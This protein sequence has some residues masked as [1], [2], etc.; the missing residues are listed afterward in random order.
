M[1]EKTSAMYDMT[2]LQ[3]PLNSGL[4]QSK[5]WFHDRV[6]FIQS[7]NDVVAAGRSKAQ[8]ENGARLVFLHRYVSGHIRGVMGDLS[9][10]RDPGEIYLIDQAR[11]VRC[12]QYPTIV[13]GVFLPKEMIGYDES[14]H[15]PFVRFG[16]RPTIGPVIYD[17]FERVLDQ[18]CRDD[19]LDTEA[20]ERLI[21]CLKLAI[22]TD[23]R[24]GD[25]RR[26]AREAMATLIRKFVEENLHQP[27][28]SST[29]ILKNF[30]VSRASLFRMF[31]RDGGVRSFI[32]KRRLNRAVFDLSQQPA[33][34]GAIGAAAYR[35]GFSSDATF[36]RAVRNAFGAPPGELVRTSRTE[37]RF[38]DAGTDILAFTQGI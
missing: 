4:Y 6:M 20:F 18:V 13:Q 9:I 34:R 22:G 1:R 17:A 19:V 10:D 7:K 28:L 15:A 29:S 8:A 2:P 27:S 36:N 38:A 21:S 5:S 32:Q 30:G 26:H 12:I 16:L 3:S 24:S 23:Q 14:A 35:W 37:S 25:V 11:R 33:T 31:E